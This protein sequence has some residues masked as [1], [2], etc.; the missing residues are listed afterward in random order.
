MSVLRNMFCLKTYRVEWMNERLQKTFTPL[1]MK[2][3]ALNFSFIRSQRNNRIHHFQRLRG[4]CKVMLNLLKIQNNFLSLQS[5]N[6]HFSARLPIMQVTI[7][8]KKNREM[9]E[10]AK[11]VDKV[12]VQCFI[13]QTRSSSRWLSRILIYFK[14]VLW[15]ERRRNNKQEIG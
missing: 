6:K 15:K 1:L 8:K 13:H 3:W 11:H 2:P 4:F 9:L 10:G 14:V 5:A 12:D 7:S